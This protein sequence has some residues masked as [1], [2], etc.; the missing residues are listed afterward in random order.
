[1][2][3][4]STTAAVISGFGSSSTGPSLTADNSYTTGSATFN[5]GVTILYK[6]GTTSS[7]E[8]T[9][10]TFG[11]TVGTGSG[12]AARVINPGSTDTPVISGNTTFNSQ[13]STLQTY[14]ATIVAAI[15]KHD[16]TNYSTGYLPV[17][18]DLSTGRTGSQYFTFKFAR[19]SVSKFDIRW[20]GTIAEIGRAHV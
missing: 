5:P 3:F 1:M 16:Q 7:M 8:E 2:L 17:G 14:D 20:T 10:I 4:R 11:S 18:P 12:L 13:T 15:L 19:T 9:T 6:T